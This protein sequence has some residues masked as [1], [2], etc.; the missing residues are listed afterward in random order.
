MAKKQTYAGRA[1]SI[2]NKYKPR[3]G[4]K[5]DKGDTLALEAMNQELDALR[6]EQEK[7]RIDKLAGEQRFEDEAVQT[8][9]DGG[10]LN[11]RQQQTLSTLLANRNTPFVQGAFQGQPTNLEAGINPVGQPSVYP[12]RFPGSEQP[13]IPR[14]GQDLGQRGAGGNQIP[15]T[16]MREARQFARRAPRDIGNFLRDVPPVTGANLTRQ[17]QGGGELPIGSGLPMLQDGDV[18][19]YSK[20]WYMQQAQGAAPGFNQIPYGQ[21]AYPQ[22]E[23]AA[24]AFTNYVPQMLQDPS[25]A[26]PYDRFGLIQG[27]SPMDPLQRGAF[28]NQY[29]PTRPTR[30]SLGL[31]RGN[32]PNQI[33]GV[34][35]TGQGPA[36]TGGVPASVYDPATGG[37]ANLDPNLGFPYAEQAGPRAGG[38]GGGVGGAGVGS[39]NIFDSYAGQNFLGRGP[40]A[41]TGFTP[42]TL[43]ATQAGALAET[44]LEG[45]DLAGTDLA[46]EPFEFRAPWLGAAASGIGSILASR[47]MDF[48]KDPFDPQQIT[49]RKVSYAREREGLRRD[50]DI[51]QAMLRRSAAQRGSISG[52]Q[53]S[54]IT[55]ATGTQRVLGRGL[56]QSLQREEA[57]NLQAGQQADVFNAQQR[58]IANRLNVQQQREN[59]LI[60]QQRRDAQ[61]AGVT[62]AV[63]GYGRDVAA[64][65]RDTGYLRLE[66]DPDYP[67]QQRDDTRLNRILRRSATPFK[68]Y[69]GPERY[70]PQYQTRY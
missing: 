22:G 15:F 34:T 70:I 55:G 6:Q 19:P 12:Q 10:K 32:V 35:V 54:L 27:T 1:K 2:M 39:G 4:E 49:P 14:G 36:A 66:E 48:E 47:Q 37:P 31:G 33:P 61:I 57:Q 60:N 17:F 68:E 52:A 51:S 11:K 9:Q 58:A 30:E 5:F 7:A 43:P 62:G 45:T 42:D 64:A 44:G 56:S 29:D 28:A 18:I 3:L 26:R 69:V 67:I 21:Q 46:G 41:Q 23:Y 53:Q 8:F 38:V 59:Q 40:A 50:R 65:R 25:L 24:N 20:E 13:V 16:S 63:T